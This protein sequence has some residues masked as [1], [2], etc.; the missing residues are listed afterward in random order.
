MTMFLDARLAPVGGTLAQ[1]V[2]VN[3]GSAIDNYAGLSLNNFLAS[4]AGRHVLVGTHGFNVDRASGIA[5]LSNWE[6]QLQLPSPSV[7]VGFLWPGDSIWGHGLDYPEEPR[8]ADAAGQ[9]L[10]TFIDATFRSAAS[11]AFASHS[12]GCRVILA[13]I[14]NSKLAVRR[15]I[16]MAGAIDAD[17]LITEYATAAERVGEISVL[18]SRKD[19]VLSML[20]PL[21]NFLGGILT[22]GHPWLRTALGHAGPANPI[23]ANLLTP[24]EIPDGWK[25]GH[26][27]Y[28]R[29]EGS[30]PSIAPADADFPAPDASEPAGGVAGW[31]SAWSA[32]V[33]SAR[34]V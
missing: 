12:L 14:A 6:R 30:G 22:V 31:Q 28:L 25:Y 11:I 29:I 1:T 16:I 18:A 9:L 7:F 3:T 17:T 23:P 2:A 34:F 13:A 8:I 5:A 21:G 24:F 32:A 10:A 27:D 20:F 33:A 26:G 4:I 15:A 19:Q